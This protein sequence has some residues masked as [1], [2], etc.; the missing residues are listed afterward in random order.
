MPS[1][2][3][4]DLLFTLFGDYFLRRSGPV[5][6]GSLIEFLE[7]LGLNEG[8]TRTTLSRMVQ[9]GWLASERVGRFSFY[10]LT[11]KARRVLEQG[12]YRI[13]HP[14]WDQPWDERWFL[15][16]YSIPEGQRTARERLRARLEWLG[17]GSL[18][19]GLWISPRN[20]EAEVAE[21]G[22]ELGLNGQLMGFHAEGPAFGDRAELVQSCWDLPAINEGY[23]AFIEHWAPVF[24]RYR[25]A[26]VGAS[27]PSG[28]P[29]SASGSANS[30][31]PANSETLSPEEAFKLRFQLIHE[32]REFPLRDP[33]LP[34]ALLPPNWGGE[35]AAHLFQHCHELLAH[36]ADRYVEEVVAHAPAVP[37]IPEPSI[38]TPS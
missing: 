29:G 18:G 23:E 32:Y 5:W 14:Q 7:K 24:T 10:H 33:Y 36:A 25:D 11:E 27:Q 34:R 21:I 20:V 4:Q 3:P 15:V 12:E 28:R 16:A 30:A 2:R 35:C 22:D 26:G 6:V 19:N 1:G 13:Y 38:P 8:A 37:G 17:F 31:I 9:R